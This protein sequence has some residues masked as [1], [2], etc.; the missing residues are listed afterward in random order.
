MIYWD[1]FTGDFELPKAGIIL[2]E[3][4]NIAELSIN[5]GIFL[6]IVAHRRSYQTN[7]AKDDVE[8][9]LGRFKVLDYS[10]EPITTYHIINNSIK[11]I[12]KQKWD[13][14]RNKYL[15]TLKLLIKQIVGNEEISVQKYM[16]KIFPYSSL[17]CVFSYF[18]C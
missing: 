9:I 16:S 7:I 11:K 1:E 8:K 5:K 3:L 15:N 10:M 18:C 17:Y 2:T 14:I 12:D 6:F 13:K 4:Q